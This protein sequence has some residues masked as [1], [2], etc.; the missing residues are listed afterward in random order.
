MEKEICS[1]PKEE[2][3]YTYEIKST[4]DNNINILTLRGGMSAEF[5]VEKCLGSL[6][7]SLSHSWCVAE[8]GGPHPIRISKDFLKLSI[9][10]TVNLYEEIIPPKMKE[11]I[12]TCIIGPGV[13]L[14]PYLCHYTRSIYL[15]SHFLVSFNLL[16]ELVEMMGQ[17]REE[18]LECH[19][20]GGYDL[21]MP[22]VG[23]AWIKL[24][25]VPQQYIDLLDKWGIREIMF[26]GN[27]RSTGECLMRKVLSGGEGQCVGLS[28]T[29]HSEYIEMRRGERVCKGDIYIQYTASSSVPVDTLTGSSPQFVG[30]VLHLNHSIKDLNEYRLEESFRREGDW[31]SGIQDQLYTLYESVRTRGITC[32]ALLGVDS[33]SLYNLA[34][35]VANSGR[36]AQPECPKLQGIAL[37]P[38]MTAHPLFEELTGYLPFCF[39]QGNSMLSLAHIFKDILSHE[40][41]SAQG[42]KIW[43]KT[44]ANFG[45]GGYGEQFMEVLR[46]LLPDISPVIPS[47]G[48]GKQEEE[49]PRGWIQW[50]SQVTHFLFTPQDMLEKQLARLPLTFDDISTICGEKMEGEVA[51]HLM[52]NNI[53]K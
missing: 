19:A 49:W 11:V 26:E 31:E 27:G 24:L 6:S 18:G 46:T 42:L 10:R 4:T 20:V 39:W 13:L 29:K 12:R 3:L 40:G 37:N 22:G 52:G 51:C 5:C 28:T 1:N 15:P 2:D 35:Y 7:G 23:V 32:R 36:K 48:Y 9:T 25:T 16:S 30:D 43:I 50:V 33:L 44:T 53:Y 17:A 21:S 47:G 38:Y 41:I 34:F 8:N 14:V 45:G